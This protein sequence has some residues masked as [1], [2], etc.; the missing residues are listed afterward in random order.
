VSPV[1]LK[2]PLETPKVCATAAIDLPEQHMAKMMMGSAHV[3]VEWS[4][5]H[6]HKRSLEPSFIWVQVA[7]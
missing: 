3:G 7:R 2:A 1:E 6:L 5:S 4:Q